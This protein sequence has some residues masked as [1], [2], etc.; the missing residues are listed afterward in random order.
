MADTTFVN[1]TTV[2]DAGWFQDL[3]NLFYRTFTSPANMQSVRNNLNTIGTAQASAATVSPP[4]NG[5]YFHIT[6]TT[7]VNGFAAVSPGY[8]V[9]VVFDSTPLLTHNATSFIMLNGANCL[10]VA[11]DV[12]TFVNESSTN[13]R[14][15]SYNG[16]GSASATPVGSYIAVG[17]ATAPN[18]TLL[19]AGQTVSRTT[20]AALFAYFGTT[21][22]SGDGST[23]YGL[24]DLRG[25]SLFGQ[26]N[27]GGTA[28]NRITSAIC[29]IT[30]TTL[31]AAGGHQDIE[32]HNHGGATG[33][34][35]TG[36]GSTGTGTSGGR[37]ADHT[38]APGSLAGTT[39]NGSDGLGNQPTATSTSA[40]TTSVSFSGNTGGASADHTH[41]VPALSVPSLSVPA[42][43]IASVGTGNAANMPPAMICNIAVKV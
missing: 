22:G 41:S 39:P 2:T 27:M 14:M 5:S 24:P 37:S 11:G 33:T 30:G 7:T 29:G 9:T 25:R 18:G 36:T 10:C 4:T 35:S 19:C 38:H 43:S 3:N 8:M 40:G 16:Y 23:T 20:Y 6:G 34:G 21:Y 17:G 26:D 13:W 28:A 12:A 15:T 1:G 31:G 32:T 42:L